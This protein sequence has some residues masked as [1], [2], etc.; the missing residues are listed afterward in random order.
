V[1]A[2]ALTADDAGTLERFVEAL[3]PANLFLRAAARRDGPPSFLGAFDGKRLRAVVFAGGSGGGVVAGD[4]AAAATLARPASARVGALRRLVGREP[5][6]RAFLAAWPGDAPFV[7]RHLHMSIASMPTGGGAPI[8]ERPRAEDVPALVALQREF[9]ADDDPPE[10]APPTEA[11]LG[12]KVRARFVAGATWV[13]REGSAL[14][15]KGDATVEEPEGAMLAGI[16]TARALRRRGLGRA[17][18]SSLV[19]TLLARGASVVTLHV[20][21]DNAAARALYDAVGFVAD[22]ALLVAYGRRAATAGV[23]RGGSRRP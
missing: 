19:A 1:D 21:E 9:H 8:V 12:S 5:E 17:G 10:A 11:D 2:R 14:V 13:L 22:D 3:P 18:T 4:P 20:A 15:W 7:R 16:A 6:A 23:A